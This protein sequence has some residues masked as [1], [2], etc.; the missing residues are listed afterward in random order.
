MPFLHIPL[1]Y[2]YIIDKNQLFLRPD[3]GL[4]SA[5]ACVE[6]ALSPC[7]A[8]AAVESK[9]ISLIRKQ[10]LSAGQCQWLHL[11]SLDVQKV[12]MSTD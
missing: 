9:Q 11:A 1:I 7:P 3:C 2:V 10:H 6:L 12:A 8:E 5:C 4:S